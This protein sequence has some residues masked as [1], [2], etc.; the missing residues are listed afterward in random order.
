MENQHENSSL[1]AS[2]DYLQEHAPASNWMNKITSAIPDS[3][4]QYGTSAATQVRNMSTTQKVA[5]GALIA[6]GAWYLANR[7]SVNSKIQSAIASRTNAI[8]GSKTKTKKNTQ[9]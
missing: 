6:A 2:Q 3:V 7:S 1:N 5:G 4:K 8:A 9:S